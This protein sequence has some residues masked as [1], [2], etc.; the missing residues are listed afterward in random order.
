MP[1]QMREI[2]FFKRLTLDDIWL[3][4]GIHTSE[5]SRIERGIFKP[6]LDKQLRI[7]TALEKSRSEVFPNE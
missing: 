7:A 4:T 1:N 2:R 5:L 3:K 6:N